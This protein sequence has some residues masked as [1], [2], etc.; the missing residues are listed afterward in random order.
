MINYSFE[1]TCQ[2]CGNKKDF[3]VMP[4]DEKVGK[5]DFVSSLQKYRIQC[6]KCNKDYLLDVR[7]TMV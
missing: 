1:L 6:K 7:L 5:D 4:I 3:Y 2:L